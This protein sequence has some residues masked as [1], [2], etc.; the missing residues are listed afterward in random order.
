MQHTEQMYVPVETD[1]R[2]IEKS[3]CTAA[4]M[5]ARTQLA[6]VYNLAAQDYFVRTLSL[7]SATGA[8][9]LCMCARAHTQLT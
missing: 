9:T 4:N 5:C 7:A 2:T 6:R 8:K 1:G 3:A